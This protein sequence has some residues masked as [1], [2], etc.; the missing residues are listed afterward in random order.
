MNGIR[1]FEFIPA[2]LTIILLIFNLILGVKLSRKQKESDKRRL[3]DSETEIGN[4]TYFKQCFDN[5]VFNFSKSHHYIA[6]IIINSEYLK[7]FDDKSEFGDTVKYTSKV[8]SSFALADD[9]VARISENGFA[10][11]FKCDNQSFAKDKIETLINKLNSFSKADDVAA[12]N[13]CYAALYNLKREDDNCETLLFNLRKNCNTIFNTENTLIVCDE[14][15]IHLSGHELEI[16]KRI[17]DGLNN[18]EFKLYLQYIVENKTGKIVSAEALSR[19]E[20]PQRGLVF[21]GEYIEI[22]ENS[23][24]ISKLDYF[25]FESV[26]KQL[27]AWQ[28]TE[29]NDVSVSCN[30]TR[31]TLSEVDFIE[32]I[33]TI[34]DKYHFKK[35]KLIIEITEDAAEKNLENAT[36]N[37]DICKKMGYSIALDDLGSGYTSLVNLCSYPIDIVKIDRDIMLKTNRNQGKNLFSGVISL[38]HNLGLKVVCEGVETD[39]QYEFVTQSECDYIQGWYFSKPFPAA[40]AKDRFDEHDITGAS[41]NVLG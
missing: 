19:W 8:L 7:T 17:S 41:R 18:S 36:S 22:M 32:K 2:V 24:L 14:S 23:A 10:F 12:S 21:P 29:M 26:C 27:E 16:V 38:A 34:A 39:E 40:L 25:M 6:Y 13:M 37:I 33:T 28:D 15:L 9:Y 35:S 11:M 31:I 20:D 1:F 30:I 5:N 4:L 3:T